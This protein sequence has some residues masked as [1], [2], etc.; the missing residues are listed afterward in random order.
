MSSDRVLTFFVDPKV[1]A[2]GGGLIV[3]K[4]GDAGF[5]LRAAEASLIEPGGQVLLSTGLF[6]AI[7]LGWVGIVKDRSSMA[8]KGLYTHGG[9]IDAAYRGELKVI[10]SN[11][12]L[13]PYKIACGDKIAQLVIV[14]CLTN[15]HEVN[16]KELLSVTDRGEGGFGSTGI[17]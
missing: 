9:V 13:E 3:P 11:R 5:D 17:R 15:A 8:S 14:P 16:S 2:A 12:G 10:I 7:P 1:K 4:E 6:F